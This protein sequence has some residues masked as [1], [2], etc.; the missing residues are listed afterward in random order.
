M[1]LE[2][3]W[4]KNIYLFWK[5]R[6]WHLTIITSLSFSQKQIR[7]LK[8]IHYFKNHLITFSFTSFDVSFKLIQSSRHQ[9]CGNGKDKSFKSW[10]EWI[11][12]FNWK[13]EL[14]ANRLNHLSIINLFFQ[15]ITTF[16]C[17][18]FIL[19]TWRGGLQK[20]KSWVSFGDR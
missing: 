12:D 7:C 19:R 14:T 4:N 1:I 15:F 11:R 10:E 18:T 5:V 3:D 9:K 13:S 6:I 8:L 20:N 17:S 16:Q 2:L